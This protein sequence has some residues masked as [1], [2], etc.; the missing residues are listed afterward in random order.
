MHLSIV[1][2]LRGDLWRRH[3]HVLKAAHS[4]VP[5]SYLLGA[6]EI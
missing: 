4:W 1:F 6:R 5:R 3:H 2:L